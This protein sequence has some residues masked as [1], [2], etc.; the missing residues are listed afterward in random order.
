M[1]AGIVI[2]GASHAGVQAALSLRQAGW[3]EP[4]RLLSAEN[5]LP[6]HRPPL[7]KAFL[8]GEK[9]AEQI[10]LRGEQFYS[11]QQVDLLLGVRAEAIDLA[12]RRIETPAGAFDFSGL[13]LATGASARRLPVA[14]ADLDGVV[15]LRDLTDA[16]GLKERLAEAGEVV[17]IGGGFI[18]LEVASTAVKSG[19][20]VT[21]IEAQDRL[22]ARALPPMLSGF[23]A[24]FHEDKGARLLFGASV[25]RIEGIAGK[26]SAIR[27]GDGTRIAADLVVV[28]IGGVANTRLGEQ[29]GLTVSAGGLLVDADARTSNPAIHAI[30]DCASFDNPYAGAPV[31]L[32]SVQNAVD[33]ARAAAAHCA[34]QSHPLKAVPWFWTDQYELKVQMAGLLTSGCEEI[35]RGDVVNGSFSLLQLK[36]GRLVSA[37]SVNRAADHMA[38]RKLIEARAALDPAA[39]RDAAVPLARTAAEPSKQTA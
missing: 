31:R 35:L 23:L 10:I 4:I 28:G 25:Q 18:G 14:G 30:G 15:T 17:V 5:D 21:V 16:R 29:A 34:G 9:D 26:V 12:A 27:L 11:E 6:Y 37:F 32:E 39:A 13:V 22:L 33:Q 36:A 2:V 8:A 7:S 3:Q 24:A 20:A 38:A 19:K 1:R